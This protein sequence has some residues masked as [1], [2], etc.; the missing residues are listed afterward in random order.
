MEPCWRHTYRTVLQSA[1][2]H[3]MGTGRYSRA[4]DE[5]GGG[6]LSRGVLFLPLD[7]FSPEAGPSRTRSSQCP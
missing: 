6:I 1:G 5:S 4:M 2:G 7:P 3:S